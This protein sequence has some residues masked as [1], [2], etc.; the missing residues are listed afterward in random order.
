[1]SDATGAVTRA[2]GPAESAVMVARDEKHISWPIARY[3]AWVFA[4]HAR[5]ESTKQIREI[6][7]TE[8]LGG[9]VLVFAPLR[10]KRAQH[11]FS[12]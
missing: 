6:Q 1:M 4:N 10:V 12:V 5:F 2:L 3:E 7:W 11:A 9:R 8:E